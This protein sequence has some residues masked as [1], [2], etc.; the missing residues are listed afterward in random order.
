MLPVEFA[1]LPN[2]E[3]PASVCIFA[4]VTAL[5]AMV[6]VIAVVPDP[7]TSPLSV[8]VWFAVRK[9]GVKYSSAVPP[10]LT[11]S[12]CRAVPSAVNPVPPLAIGS[13]P[14]T[15]EAR[16]VLPVVKPEPLPRSGPFREVV[17]ASVPDDVTGEPDT[18]NPE[19]ME[20]PTDVT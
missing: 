11:R 14:V 20:S 8:M 15:S 13:V 17:T 5:L 4:T 3:S 18:E 7:V 6:V 9:E 19:G 12:N 2:T 1:D 16:F 10:E